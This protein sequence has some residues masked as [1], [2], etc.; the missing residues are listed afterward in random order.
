MY[1]D[2][3]KQRRAVRDATRRY[4]ARNKVS[5]LSGPKQ[6]S[7]NARGCLRTDEV[8]DTQAVIPCDTQDVIPKLGVDIDEFPARDITTQ[9]YNPMMV[10]YVPPQGRD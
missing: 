7:E 9:S 8:G 2:K 5:A 6:G 1:K 10:G 4:R 3:D